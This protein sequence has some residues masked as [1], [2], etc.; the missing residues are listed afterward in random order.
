MSTTRGNEDEQEMD[1]EGQGF[2]KVSEWTR[3]PHTLHAQAMKIQGQGIHK[4]KT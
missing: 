2:W 4:C 1:E 3:V